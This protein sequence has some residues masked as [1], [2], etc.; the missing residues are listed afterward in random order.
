MDMQLPAPYTPILFQ[1]PMPHYLYIVNSKITT[2]ND[3]GHY[4]EKRSRTF[5]YI[6]FVNIHKSCGLNFKYFNPP[7]QSP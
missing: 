5:E 6:L 4:V 7:L 2:V 3:S 1:V